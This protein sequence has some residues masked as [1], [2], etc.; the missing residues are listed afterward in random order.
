LLGS[1]TPTALNEGT[2]VSFGTAGLVSFIRSHPDQLIT[3]IVQRADSGSGQSR[4]MTKEASATAFN[5]AS[6]SV[7]DFAPRLTFGNPLTAVTWVGPGNDWNQSTNWFAP[8][9]P[10]NGLAAI[11]S[12]NFTVN[13]TTPMFASSFSGLTN[14]SVLNINTNGFVIDA[15][16]GSPL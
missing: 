5:I 11:I 6:G 13:Y 8:F 2:V 10:T 4:F 15:A 7:G 14:A 3:I 9:V 12:S 1:V 16:G